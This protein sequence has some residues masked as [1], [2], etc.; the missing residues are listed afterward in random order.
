MKQ[1]LILLSAVMIAG[2]TSLATVTQYPSTIGISASG[3]SGSSSAR[4]SVTSS[5]YLVTVR[6]IVESKSSWLNS[7][8]ADVVGQSDNCTVGVTVSASGNYSLSQRTGYVTVK[9][10]S[11]SSSSTYYDSIT[12]NV[13]Q[14]GYNATVLPTSI[15][16]D[17]TTPTFSVNVTTASGVSWQASSS[18]SWITPNSTSGSGSSAA[19]F[20]LAV[21]NSVDERIGYV[22]VAQQKITV[23]QRGRPISQIAY[24]NLR[25]VSHDNPTSYVEGSEI[26]FASPSSSVPGYTFSGWNPHKITSTMTGKQ[27]IYASWEAN[28]YYVS[29][30]PNGG[31]GDMANQQIIYDAVTNINPVAFTRDGYEFIGWSTNGTEDVAYEDNAPVSNL[32][33]MANGVVEFSAVW[34]IINPNPPM[35]TPSSGTVISGTSLSISMSCSS[36]DA[37]IYCTTDGTEPTEESPVYSR[38]KIYDK[39]VVKAIAILPNG[40]RSDVVTAEYAR[41][42]CDNPNISPT[43]QTAFYHSNQEVTIQKVGA[44]GVLRYTVDGSDPTPESP[45]YTTA[46]TISES[47]VV[48]AKVF[49][50]TFFDSDVVTANLIREW[51]RVETPVVH[52][53][54]E[55]T[56]AETMV[57]ISCGTEGAT[58]WYTIDGGEPNSHSPKYKE[59]FYIREGCVVKAIAAKT[60]YTASEVATFTVTKNWDI[61]DSMGMPDHAF[62]TSPD[63]PF[64]RVIDNSSPIGESMKS[65]A[66]GNSEGLMMYN[67]T[68]LETKVQGPGEV[69][70]SWKAS[71]EQDD[72]YEWDHAEFSIDGVIVD[73]IHGVTPW[74][75]KSFH[76]SGQGEHNIAW[77]YLKDNEE[78][79]GEDCIWVSCFNWVPAE[80]YTH[81]SDVQVPYDWITRYYPH[82]I[83]EYE[84]YETAVK[85]PASNPLYTIEEA[86]LIGISPTNAQAKFSASISISNGIPCV[87][88]TPNLNTNGVVRTYK[89]YGSETLYNGGEWQ[90]PTN[91]LHRFFKVKVEMP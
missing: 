37:I 79:A 68:V 76:V 47:T 24:E 63:V 55:F 21:N 50:D 18:S 35:I 6:A 78:K 11:A 53:E 31:N 66:I 27:T 16:V 38:F 56:G 12:F 22:T 54:S 15:T 32:T 75:N 5:S 83:K 84:N 4:V 60:D 57:R 58:I 49:S 52:A 1:K 33:A 62:T 51:L 44:E 10:G 80:P 17:S 81:E 2:I 71:C 88:W 39:I 86:Y 42:C 61:G 9:V 77:T 91:S 64:T 36:E 43:D 29:F 13:T 82:T 41:G 7:A 89:V 34:K 90:Y 26:S 73:R 19:V 28:K 87:T 25:G 59:P 70:F 85:L 14:F 65:G 72:E 46:F 67:R 3:G 20:S 48:K 45:P 30:V 8:T 74:Q 69:S 40:A 23:L